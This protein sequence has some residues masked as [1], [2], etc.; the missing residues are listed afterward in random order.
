MLKSQTAERVMAFMRNF[1]SKREWVRLHKADRISDA[2]MVT[3]FAKQFGMRSEDKASQ[4]LKEI[5][6]ADTTVQKEF[7]DIS[8]ERYIA[9]G[10]RVMADMLVAGAY[11]P[12]ATMWKSISQAKG[13]EKQNLQVEVG[14][15]PEMTETIRARMASLLADRQ[16]R[17]T[18]EAAQ[19]A[20]HVREQAA[21]VNAE[22]KWIGPDRSLN[23]LS[24][25]QAA[26]ETSQPAS[27]ESE[28]RERTHQP[29]DPPE[30]FVADH[31]ALV[32]AK[33]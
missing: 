29:P 11:G 31:V 16:V 27:V 30:H 8:R 14:P 33:K 3:A 28:P 23:P 22:D 19:L 12:A 32:L 15:S 5:L 1:V 9:Q 4:E 24:R 17:E 10:E 20:E 6:E 13:F 25:T 2:E 26:V 21:G 7:G 18:A